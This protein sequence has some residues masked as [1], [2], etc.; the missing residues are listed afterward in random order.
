MSCLFRKDVVSSPPLLQIAEGANDATYLFMTRVV[1]ACIPIIKKHEISFALITANLRGRPVVPL[2]TTEEARKA[3][4]I[5]IVIASCRR[6]VSRLDI[7]LD[8]SLGKVILTELLDRK[9]CID[10]DRLYL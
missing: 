1:V 2:F 5:S 6:K 8:S 10:S 9:L 4:T 7:L 3:R